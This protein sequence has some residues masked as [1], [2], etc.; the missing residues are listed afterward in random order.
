MF[1]SRMTKTRITLGSSIKS[2]P[3]DM[4]CIAQAT[5]RMAV[6]S[7]TPAP[8]RF[9]KAITVSYSISAWTGF[10]GAA[11]SGSLRDATKISRTA[12]PKGRESTFQEI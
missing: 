3:I 9:G 8:R 10:I 11:S 12:T 7:R 2:R 6:V 1:E 4:L 5:S